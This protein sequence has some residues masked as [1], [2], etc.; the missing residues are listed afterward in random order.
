LGGLAGSFCKGENA[1]MRFA[2]VSDIHGNL[3]AL[4]VV[5]ADL[6]QASVDG[7]VCLGDVA[8]L[9]PQPREV[10]A[11]LRQLQ[12]PVVMGNHDTYLLNPQ[13]TE[14]HH[15]W[16][17]AAEQ[18][19]LAQLSEDDLDFV[20]SFQPRLSFAVDSNTTLLCFHG[21]PR[22][23]EEWLYPTATS[24]TLDEIFGEQNA[25]VWVGGHTHV[26]LARQHKGKLLLNPG[27]VGMPC[28][29]PMR[30]PN[31]RILR[32][33]EYAI[34][35]IANGRFSASLHRLPIDFERMAQIARASGLPDVEFW[36]STWV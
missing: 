36:L 12:I 1:K 9:G 30:G 3:Q 24:E 6:R 5:L 19:C 11:C 28:E 8:S 14:K 23:N 17:R 15:P 31:Q 13:L 25:P 35:E 33:A 20:R 4:E 2:F 26:Q 16:L 18:W 10:L 7:L 22:S 29:F 34:L 32:W 27:S 21:S